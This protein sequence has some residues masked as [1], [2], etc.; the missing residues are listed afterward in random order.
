[1][2]PFSGGNTSAA[3]APAIERAEGIRS[4]GS[5]KLVALLF[6]VFRFHPPSATADILLRKGVFTAIH[7]NK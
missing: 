4:T 6:Q 2:K 5:I 1:L 7:Q 3:K